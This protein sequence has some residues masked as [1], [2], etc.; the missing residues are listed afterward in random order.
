MMRIEMAHLQDQGI[1]F[2]VFA[3]DAARQAARDSSEP[4]SRQISR[5]TRRSEVDPHARRL[6][7]RRNHG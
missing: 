4:G 6:S 3:A 7:G 1:D 2:A 5:V